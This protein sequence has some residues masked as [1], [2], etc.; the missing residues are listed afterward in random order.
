MNKIIYIALFTISFSF[1]SAAGPELS[2]KTDRSGSTERDYKVGDLI[3]VDI[4][5]SSNTGFF[6]AHYSLQYPTEAVDFIKAEPGN[7]TTNQGAYGSFLYAHKPG[8]VISSVTLLDKESTLDEGTFARYYF[9]AKKI[10][11]LVSFQ[12]IPSETLL[13]DTDFNEVPST[14]NAFEPFSI[15]ENND[16]YLNITDPQNNIS[17]SSLSVDVT[18]VYNK[19][20]P[21]QVQFF[22]RSTGYASGFMSD[23][24]GSV[25]HPVEIR[26]GVNTIEA[27]L[28][29]EQREEVSTPQASIIINSVPPSDKKIEI[30]SHQSHSIVDTDTVVL[31]ITSFTNSV[32]INEM[33]AVMAGDDP[34]I[35]GN[36]LFEYTLPL[37]EGF[38]TIT[39]STE[40]GGFYY[41]DT[42]TLYYQKNK[43]SFSF[44][45]PMDN[46][47]YKYKAHKDL[48]ITGFIGS[49]KK[50]DGTEA[51]I[52][53]K[54]IHHP[55]SAALNST[56]IEESLRAIIEPNTSSDY[57]IAPFTFRLPDSVDLERDFPGELRNLTDGKLEIIAYKNKDGNSYEEAIHRFI[58]LT[59]EELA[60]EIIRPNLYGSDKL[61]SVDEINAFTPGG[62]DKASQFSELVPNSSGY[63][64][65]ANTNNTGSENSFFANT[66]LQAITEYSGDLYALANAANFM[67]I[68]KKVQGSDIWTQIITT[69]GDIGYSLVATD[70][71]LF[72][73]LKNNTN[74]NGL[75][76]IENDNLSPI[77]LSETVSNVQ[78]IQ[79]NNNKISLYNKGFQKY[80]YSFDIMSLNRTDNNGSISYSLNS[81]DLEKTLVNTGDL[82]FKEF[83]VSDNLQYAVALESEGY[84]R[85]F[86][87][88]NSVLTPFDTFTA[89]SGLSGLQF[90]S[91]IY[92]NYSEGDYEVY[93][94]L[95]NNNNH[96]TLTINTKTGIINAKPL[97]ISHLKG[98]AFNNN[99]FTLLI[100]DPASVTDTLQVKRGTVY[101]DSFYPSTQTDFASVMILGNSGYKLTNSV[102]NTIH[103]YTQTDYV[104][105]EKEL[106]TVPQTVNIVY[107]N[108][109]AVDIKGFSFYT[110]ADSINSSGLQLAFTPYTINPV[111]NQELVAIFT[112]EI[113]TINNIIT[114]SGE[115]DNPRFFVERDYDHLLNKEKITI[116]FNTNHIVNRLNV[117][118]KMTSLDGKSHP[119]AGLF[120]INKESDLLLPAG[121]VSTD[122][123]IQG[124]INDPTVT[125][126]NIQNIDGPISVLSD[127]TFSAVYTIT[128][129]GA[130][131]VT[132]E[133]SLQT[134]NKE[135]ESASKSFNVT[136]FESQREI[137]IESLTNRNS[138]DILSESQISPI[139][140]LDGLLN[141][142]GNFVGLKGAQVGYTA[143]DASHNVLETHYLKTNPAN[144]I[145]EANLLKGYNNRFYDEGTIVNQNILLHKNTSYIKFFIEDSGITYSQKIVSNQS[146]DQKF[147]FAI[148]GNNSPQNIVFT[149]AGMTTTD[150]TNYTYTLEL[151][152]KELSPGVYGYSH[153]FILRGYAE[154]PGYFSS[155]K[156]K[157][158]SVEGLKF[159]GNTSEITIPVANDGRFAT[160]VYLTPNAPVET[161][162]LVI[163]VTP[164]VDVGTPITRTLTIEAN[165][166]FSDAWITP[167]FSLMNSWTTTETLQGSKEIRVL[168]DRFI[169]ENSTM[170]LLV[171]S[172]HYVSG[173]LTKSGNYYNLVN[174]QVI[175]SLNNIKPGR[176]LIEW[177]IYHEDHG[178]ISSSKSTKPSMDEFTFSVAPAAGT[179]YLF[180]FFPQDLYGTVAGNKPVIG[181]NL[182][183]TGVYFSVALN[184]EYIYDIR[185]RVDIN[186]NTLDLSVYPLNE[187]RNKISTL[188]YDAT[189]DEPLTQEFYFFYDS[190]LPEAEFQNL[191]LV[192][193]KP[194]GLQIN[195]TEAN[196]KSVELSFRG[197]ENILKITQ[198]P[199]MEYNGEGLYSFYW[200]NLHTSYTSLHNSIQVSVS[201][202]A[203]NITPVTL[204]SVDYT[205]HEAGDSQVLTPSVPTLPATAYYAGGT[206]HIFR[207]YS[208]Y[209]S[210]HSPAGPFDNR[211]IKLYPSDISLYNTYTNGD[212]P[213]STSSTKEDFL[214]ERPGTITLINTFTYGG[215]S[216]S[217][218]TLFSGQGIRFEKNFRWN[219]NTQLKTG[220]KSNLKPSSSQTLQ[221]HD[222]PGEAL[223]YGFWLRKED[224]VNFSPNYGVERI[225]TLS[226]DIDNRKKEFFLGSKRT[227]VGEY[228]LGLYTWTGTEPVQVP[229]T[230]TIT[231]ETYSE[232]K[233][234]WNFILLSLDSVSSKV[235][236]IINNKQFIINTV[237]NDYIQEALIEMNPYLG[238]A[239]PDQAGHFSIAQLFTV[240]GVAG[241]EELLSMKSELQTLFDTAVDGSF[242]NW[243][244]SQERFY[245]FNNTEDF[246]NG[247]TDLYKL[248]YVKNSNINT[249]VPV[250][251]ATENADFHGAA[252]DGSFL[253]SNTHNNIL[254]RNNSN[255]FTLMQNVTYTAVN[256]TLTEL[257][258]SPY[259]L[260][261]P[262]TE[263]VKG[264]Y[265]LAQSPQAGIIQPGQTYSLF[266]SLESAVTDGSVD[267]VITVTVNNEEYKNRVTQEGPFHFVFPINTSA[268]PTINI[269]IETDRDLHLKK[270]LAFIQGG[271][272]LP[273][274]GEQFFVNYEPAYLKGHFNFNTQGTIDFWYKPVNANK[275]SGVSQET[276]LFQSDYIAIYTKEHN[277]Q[278]TYHASFNDVSSPSTPLVLTSNRVMNKGWQHI[279]LSYN[280][281]EAQLY[282]NGESVANSFSSIP[283]YTASDS[284]VYWGYSGNPVDLATGYIDDI[285]LK[286]TYETSLYNS[287]YRPFTPQ[288]N[289]ETDSIELTN[290]STYSGQVDFTLKNITWD[291]E[292]SY[293]ATLNSLNSLSLR[294]FV[295]DEALAGTYELSYKIISNS[296]RH[297]GNSYVFHKS[298][299]PYLNVTQN[300]QLNISGKANTLK[301]K[302]DH[303]ENVYQ[304]KDF[305]AADAFALT[306]EYQRIHEAMNSIEIINQNYFAAKGPALSPINTWLS[307]E[308]P[309]AGFTVHGEGNS[310]SI[311]VDGIE[312]D[313]NIIWKITPFYTNRTTPADIKTA[314]IPGDFT[315]GTSA[316]GNISQTGTIYLTDFSVIKGTYTAQD[317]SGLIVP[318]EYKLNI[319]AD[320]AAGIPRDVKNTLQ[321]ETELLDNTGSMLEKLSTD[322]HSGTKEIYYYELMDNYG[323]YRVRTFLK[324]DHYTYHSI[325]SNIQ[326]DQ[327]TENISGNSYSKMSFNSLT[328][329]S[330][331]RT[332]NTAKVE[333]DWSVF[334]IEP[335][336]ESSYIVTPT[337]RIQ[338]LN[339]EELMTELNKGPYDLSLTNYATTITE[340]IPVFDGLSE[341]TV[342][343]TLT[344]RTDIN[345]RHTQKRTVEINNS[346]EAPKLILT[347]SV[348][349]KIAYNNVTLT[350][351]GQVNNEVND[352]VEF[353]FNYNNKGWNS[354]ST[355]NTGVSFFKL[356]DGYHSLKIKARY[357]GV[358]SSERMIS[359]LVDV[360][361]P[362]F[363]TQ[364]IRLDPVTDPQ[365][366]YTTVRLTG[367]AGAVNDS[368]LDYLMWNGQYIPNGIDT[369]KPY[370][371]SEGAFLTAPVNVNEEGMLSYTLTAVDRTGNRTDYSVTLDNSLM[372]ITHPAPESSVKYAPVTIMGVLNSR[373]ASNVNIYLKDASISSNDYKNYWKKATISKDNTFFIDDIIINPGKDNLTVETD[374]ELILETESLKTYKKRVSVKANE[375]YRPVELSIG[376]SSVRVDNDITISASCNIQN[377][378]Q[379]GIDFTGDGIYDQWNSVNPNEVQNSMKWTTSY[380]YTG[381]YTPR[382]RIITHDRKYLSSEITINVYD[383]IKTQSTLP[384]LNNVIDYAS[385]K[386]WDGSD[387]LFLLMNNA[388]QYGI[389]FYSVT[390]GDNPQLTYDKAGP[391]LTPS[392]LNN[393]VQI[394][395]LPNNDFVI[396]DQGT[397]VSTLRHFKNNEGDYTNALPGGFSLEGIVNSVKYLNNKLYV[398]YRDY[399]HIDAFEIINGNIDTEN[400]RLNAFIPADIKGQ[401]LSPNL[402]LSVLNSDLIISDRL[403][404]QVIIRNE[405]GI[406]TR[407]TGSTGNN[408]Y[409][410]QD[411]TV[412]A[413]FDDK[414]AVYDKTNKNIQI[415]SD[416]LELLTTINAANG[417]KDA[418]ISEEALLDITA[419]S[420]TTRVDE[421]RLY[422][423]LQYYS[424]SNNELK[425]LKLPFNAV[426]QAKV[427][428]N[429]IVFLKNNEMYMAKPTGKHMHKLLSSSNRPVESGSLDYPELS[430]DGRFVAF[431]SSREMYSGNIT[432]G[433]NLYIL[434]LEN[435]SVEDFT[436]KDFAAWDIERPVYN[437][438]G[439]KLI[440]AARTKTTLG[441]NWSHW[442]VYET[443]IQ[444]KKTTQLNIPTSYTHLNHPAYSPD[445]DYIVYTVTNSGS[446]QNIEVMNLE[447]KV[448]FSVTDATNYN[449]YYPVWSKLAAGEITNTQT[450]VKSKIAFTSN[451]NHQS[452]IYYAYAAHENGAFKLLK[453]TGSTESSITA[454]SEAAI[455]VTGMDSR[456]VNHSGN[457]PLITGDGENILF[458]TSEGLL[459]SYNVLNNKSTKEIV[460]MDGFTGI[461][462]PAGMKSRIPYVTAVPEKQGMVISWNEYTDNSNTLYRVIYWEE[463][464]Y[465]KTD[466]QFIEAG[467]TP[468][469][470]LTVRNL[471][472][473]KKYIFMVQLIEN[474]TPIISSAPVL[475]ATNNVAANITTEVDAE[476]PYMYTFTAW[477]PSDPALSSDWEYQWTIDNSVIN[478]NDPKSPTMNYIFNS[479]GEKLVSLKV[480]SKSANAEL[481]EQ[482]ID[483]KT[484]DVLSHIKP[485]II[486]NWE[487]TAG[488]LTLSAEN[489]E[490]YS[491]VDTS[492]ITWSITGSDI[493]AADIKLTGPVVSTLLS[494]NSSKELIVN[495]SFAKKP[496]ELQQNSPVETFNTYKRIYTDKS[497]VK[498]VITYT[499]TA[500]E[501]GTSRYI[502]SGEDSQGNID[503][504]NAEWKLML[505]GELI[506]TPQA[507][508]KSTWIHIGAT[509]DEQYYE[510]YLSITGSNSITKTT[511]IT[512]SPEKGEMEPYIDYEVVVTEE[513]N[514]TKTAK[515]V[516]DARGSRGQNINHSKTLWT[517]D[518]VIKKG[519]FAF[520]EKQSTTPAEVTLTLFRGET[521]NDSI[522]RTRIINLERSHKKAPEILVEQSVKNSFTEKTLILDARK[523]LGA[524][525][526]WLKTSWEINGIKTLS[527]PVAE[528]DIPSTVH[529]GIIPW[530]VTLM[531][532]NG[533]TF[534]QKGEYME[535]LTSIIPVISTNKTAGNSYTF[536]VLTTR[537]SHIDW[538]KT[539]WKFI[540]GN[541]HQRTVYGPIASHT[542]TPSTQQK[543]Y[544]V[545]VIMY[546]KNS[547]KPFYGF[548]NISQEDNVWEP[549]IHW[550]KPEGSQDPNTILFS[551]EQSMGNNIL[552]SKSQW[553]FAD[554][555]VTNY[556]V[557]AL[558]TFPVLSN[559]GEKSHG[560]KVT[561]TLTRLLPDGTEETKSATRIIDLNNEDIKSRLHAD[562]NKESGILKLSSV[563]SEGKGLLLDRTIWVFEDEG[564]ISTGPINSAAF[565]TTRISA[566]PASNQQST[567]E[568][569][570]SSL[571]ESGSVSGI[572][573]SDIIEEIKKLTYIQ[574]EI[575]NTE[576][577][578]FGKNP[579]GPVIHLNIEPG[580]QFIKIAMA[581]YKYNSDGSVTAETLMVN[582]DLE[583]ASQD[584]GY[585]YE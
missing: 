57:R 379:W 585:L 76:L 577:I 296:G 525:I 253:L 24:A 13:M 66:Q 95:D 314:I 106:P 409:E 574:Q 233:N 194:S 179:A 101:F 349:S 437:S 226:N 342:E 232:T 191:S 473:G 202:G 366:F 193:G 178:I 290:K 29:N 457:Y 420:F 458:A 330:V 170:F 73:G 196:L 40:E 442:S 535:S 502:F 302:L 431:T 63:L 478:T 222:T 61:Y 212:F 513:T 470:T 511:A 339:N 468:E 389:H 439:T 78:F 151:A 47:Y 45:Y 543:G 356:K 200:E 201:D 42:I 162:N 96:Q 324:D 25:I 358:E 450:E 515:L 159:H 563:N 183:A 540:D 284:T 508:G 328:I 292:Y 488:K 329:H 99:M 116:T 155:I 512:F 228:T 90:S 492:T 70:R 246:T 113:N 360:N 503:W 103:V 452:D 32:N 180:D 427:N 550:T 160:Y 189:T 240:N 505:N 340:T 263:G 140:L 489:S 69:S 333:M 530:T 259:I 84:L 527:G 109:D 570:I 187:G 401:P 518:G 325:E 477:T 81:K 421:D 560:N 335:G 199:R 414:I 136:L 426:L 318:K 148:S 433:N 293:S 195:I 460:T 578:S 62:I 278:I 241:P 364:K 351:Q 341:V 16:I 133:I 211:I 161:E 1:L 37:T 576:N 445:D 544:T 521:M 174:N 239:A 249:A 295:Q 52:D 490:G 317:N 4:D 192:H 64:T 539:Q 252:G 568:K 231:Y 256:M 499:E 407:T 82:I 524:N 281:N 68:Y 537:G 416:K 135:G 496:S 313:S 93:L 350:W 173:T 495:L 146:E 491:D 312:A 531:T 542:F 377:I 245:R 558:H 315:P 167:D 102:N 480:I 112:E 169:P 541:P 98:A 294:T 584:K 334:G 436:P 440:F 14:L 127:G 449:N 234:L 128:P 163:D 484:I 435:Q 50:D 323:S 186:N 408:A 279:Q 451:R 447:H 22:N 255:I 391:D 402:I 224:E 388:G 565:S 303:K 381:D 417:I 227:A 510:L 97:N 121:D 145:S 466:S 520:F 346:A 207:M 125:E 545:E 463:T 396:I 561:L 429:R 144:K 215:S 434:N 168:F 132:E 274:M 387:R 507:S 149:N 58:Y 124:F 291:K 320:R 554:S 129:E 299:V 374:L 454:L 36:T 6:G 526:D 15:I 59:S 556:G 87:N 266:G 267:A 326:W 300:S 92:G 2:I 375:L 254:Y 316:S 38:N 498:P 171:N 272:S 336:T 39:A 368:A 118:V 277:G 298:N 247:D 353:S 275:N 376:S 572:S 188:I 487:S 304:N 467:K 20:F 114:A 522:S 509:S 289:S 157:S 218:V 523:T 383:D 172:Q 21:Y 559:N 516:L 514:G 485:V 425:L 210:E 403:K 582:I 311:S 104:L 181:V 441:G 319:S 371:N 347:N 150:R 67:Y 197:P 238:F 322:F 504:R 286:N 482:A 461:S 152:D 257:E 551:A 400:F 494:G 143:F 344:H 472:P 139:T 380:S 34:A 529:R 158:N 10:T 213:D 386:K 369:E 517:I 571:S 455:R 83:I 395:V 126:V 418:Y 27:V 564:Y 532:T 378:A 229:G 130:Y 111:T 134:N 31:T 203:G 580:T 43:S 306:L 271:F 355:D 219:N 423:Y 345:F 53:L 506:L 415:F 105:L 56:V 108:S 493:T 273:A 566:F 223:T 327:N 555:S 122:I 206:P 453:V 422:Y 120:T 166:S 567:L 579:S 138:A 283:L 110:D 363:D 479:S 3:T 28:Y 343:L 248:R 75:Y 282:V 33:P 357:Q 481:T 359:F 205:S 569:N 337:F 287:S 332:D 242:H 297:Y 538:D 88:E 354:F 308:D 474:N 309:G 438:Q 361:P 236:I 382:I 397:S 251:S 548:T 399:N 519:P 419:M 154:F 405:A 185:E 321:I 175:Q 500:L 465:Y 11:S 244:G 384:G 528:V 220:L 131:P 153:T 583:K 483:V 85:L 459:K 198:E 456:D 177:E 390:A 553:S 373:I 285:R 310:V 265:T 365:G 8:V 165:K 549:I 19:N 208:E 443:D 137:Q 575:T 398:S 48:D 486:Y 258:A 225:L 217:K 94:L 410:F 536:D 72:L 209:S 260:L 5:I 370:W 444:E 182:P 100:N 562:F 497:D 448:I 348:D 394:E 115:G 412:L 237:P 268:D 534:I 385:V 30:I 305:N 221:R 176:N 147:F 235:T 230:Q 301:F 261:S 430:P 190:Q 464:D 262:Q 17:V 352:Q 77:N 404:D 432:D 214:H 243:V 392:N 573:H 581:V 9:R 51:T 501:D 184:D 86:K 46:Q 26:Q 462:R 270:D 393:P 264:V 156:L 362:V 547:P 41:E 119:V 372:T 446:V 424:A 141:I 12:L 89:A 80:I 35:N 142:S 23:P 60:I 367:E 338:S 123:Q 533:S 428:V 216:A 7:F 269:S 276:Y 546:S 79:N 55:R 411:A 49:D 91:A 44:V 54:L 475:I 288:W 557:T 71:G 117:S 406:T 552:W 469:K 107:E 74:N 280:Q 476:N 18:A 250:L 307:M 471:D 331:N 204:T 164:L 65:Y 413:A